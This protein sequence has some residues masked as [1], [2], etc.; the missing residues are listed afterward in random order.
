MI[1]DVCDALNES[2]S[3]SAAT[4]NKITLRR[5]SPGYG[6]FPIE[7]QKLFTVLLNTPKNIGAVLTE[8]MMLYPTKTVTA[9]IGIEEKT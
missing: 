6:D 7:T 9:I 4:E 1:E 5:Y 8:G 2:L 3:R